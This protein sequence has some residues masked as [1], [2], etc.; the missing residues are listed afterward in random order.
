MFFVFKDKI[1]HYYAYIKTYLQ[2]LCRNL[3]KL[4]FSL[5]ST[6]EI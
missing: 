4:H 1:T 6:D 5:Q 3:Q 2:I